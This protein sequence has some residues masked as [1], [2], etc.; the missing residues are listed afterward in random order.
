MSNKSQRLS[1][2]IINLAD[3]Q[4]LARCLQNLDPI[5]AECIVVLGWDKDKIDTFASNFPKVRFLDAGQKPVPQQRLLGANSA[6]GQ[7]VAFLED[8]S[9]PATGWLEAIKRT[10]ADPNVMVAGGP[11]AISTDLPPR[12]RALACVEYGYF[13]P[14][15]NRAWPVSSPP[16]NNFVCRRKFL[17]KHLATHPDGLIETEIQQSLN[18]SGMKWVFNPRLKVNYIAP[19]SRGAKLKSRVQHGRLFG[20]RRIRGEKTVVRI[21]WVIKSLALPVILPWRRLRIL[22][23]IVE[24]S[25]WLQVATWICLLE[26]A[27]AAGESFGYLAGEGR[28]LY[29]WR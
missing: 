22:P 26:W 16:G 27:W 11:V 28:S 12:Y 20:A 17:L 14:S 1:V 25:S 15:Q 6:Q 5:Q 18:E 2:V 23:G 13:H 24:P 10:F 4:A 7:F 29:A 8:T 19:H 9:L 21:K 3:T